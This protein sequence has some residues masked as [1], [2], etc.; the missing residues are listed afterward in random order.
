MKKHFTSLFAALSLLI[1]APTMVQAAL[2]TSAPGDGTTT[3]LSTITGTWSSAPSVNAGGYNIFAPPGSE[4]WYGDSSYGL[5]D[6]GSW[7]NFAWVGGYCYSGAC[8]ATID[9][10]DYIPLLVD[11]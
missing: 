6:N 1:A 9:L 5:L 10:V 3:V 11:S 4:V 7:S 8:T 2:I